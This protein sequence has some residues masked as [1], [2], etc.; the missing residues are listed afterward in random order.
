[1]QHVVEH[2]LEPQVLLAELIFRLF[3]QLPPIQFMLIGLG[4]KM[5]VLRA[6]PLNDSPQLCPDL[7]HKSQKYLI[8]LEDLVSKEFQYSCYFT[9]HENGKCE[10]RLYS[11]RGGSLSAREIVVVDNIND[12]RRGRCCQDPPGQS[13]AG[14]KIGPL[15]QV[16]EWS[17]AVR[18]RG[19]TNAC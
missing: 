12:P 3:D 16:T 14:V 19:M 9:F 8:R 10:G 7:R 5:L 18:I 17:C 6:F 2:N 1:M 11:G 4:S 13:D 15:A